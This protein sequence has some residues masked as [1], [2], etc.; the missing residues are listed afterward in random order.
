MQQR[1]E[2]AHNNGQLVARRGA[3]RSSAAVTARPA[4]QGLRLGLGVNERQEVLLLFALRAV[5]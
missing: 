4:G 3:T 1:G 5:A 2:Q